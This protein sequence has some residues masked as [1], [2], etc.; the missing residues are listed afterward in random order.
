M[1]RGG[2]SRERGGHP[3]SLA[4]EGDARASLDRGCRRSRTIATHKGPGQVRIIAG[5]WRRSVLPVLDRPGL[6]PTPDRVR[7]TAFNWISARLGT[8]LVGRRVLDAFAGTGALG[9]EAASRGADSVYLIE[10]DPVCVA[11]LK[12]QIERFEAGESIRVLGADALGFLS[13]QPTGSYDLIFLDPPFEQGL[14]PR[15]LPLAARC[16]NAH[17]LIYVESEQPLDRLVQPDEMGGLQVLRSAR[18]GAV[19]HALLSFALDQ[20]QEAS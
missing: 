6:R 4:E 5:Q 14:I 3:A 17:G 1:D 7:E 10:R 2:C 18:A 19:F 16:L 13:A 11:S 9:F 8:H 12:A 20:H 15:S